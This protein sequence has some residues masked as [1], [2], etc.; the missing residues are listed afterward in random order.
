MTNNCDFWKTL[1]WK[2][3]RIPSCL[4][5]VTP[6][7]EPKITARMQAVINILTGITTF[8]L[9]DHRHRDRLLKEFIQDLVMGSAVLLTQLMDT[10][11]HLNKRL[12]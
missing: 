4:P 10:D 12:S 11:E 2:K 8:F 1:R 7:A 6:K 5:N 3:K 9:R